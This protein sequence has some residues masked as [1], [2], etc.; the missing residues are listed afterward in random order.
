MK[1]VGRKREQDDIAQ[2]LAS[3]RPEF[4]VV[5]GRRRVGKTYLIREYF[6][7]S[8]AFYA[9]GLSSASKSSQL[10]AFQDSLLRYGSTEKKAPSDWFEAFSRLRTLLESSFIK[11]DPVY[12]RIVVFLDELPWMDTPKSDFKSALDYFWNSWGSS[13]SELVLIVCGSAT[14]WIVNHFLLDKGGFHN[15]VTRRMHLLPFTLKEC[16][17]LLIYNG[18]VMPRQQQIECYMVF[19]GIPFYLN[20]LDSRLS[21]HQNIEELCFKEYGALHNEYREL[22]SSLFKKPVKHIAIIEALAQKKAGISRTEL[23]KQDS[24]GGGSILTRNLLELEECGFLRK[25]HNLRAAKNEAIYQLIDPFVLFSLNFLQKKT[26][27]SWL[28]KLNS[29]EYLSWRGNAFEIVSTIHIPQI[30]KALGI[31]GVHS[32][33]ASWRSKNKEHGAQID[34]LINRD[35]GIINLCEMKFTSEEFELDK[36][37]AMKLENRLTCFQKESNTKKAIHITLIAA[38]GMKRNQYSGIVQNLLVGDDLF[39]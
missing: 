32:Q 1:I 31:E 33:E 25:V 38:N 2:F 37:E 18:N 5:Y 29:P 21:L 7:D 19:G 4:V 16:E 8:L 35:D 28:G 26:S 11:K 30:K 6:K 27:Y 20:L 17:E 3:G 12:G 22:F 34:L 15:R 9:T 10:K 13:V 23:E 14:S 36:I 39:S 24:I